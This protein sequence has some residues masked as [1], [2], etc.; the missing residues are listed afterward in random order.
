MKHEAHRLFLLQVLQETDCS[1]KH[2]ELSLQTETDESVASENPPFLQR[3]C[4]VFLL[5]SSLPYNTLYEHNIL[6]LL[7]AYWT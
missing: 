6:V 5:P 4:D 2:E 1:L 3:P 7:N